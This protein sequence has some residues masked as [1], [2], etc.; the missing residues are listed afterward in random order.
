MPVL[1]VIG[2]SPECSRPHTGNMEKLLPPVFARLV[3]EP[4]PSNRT[5][6]ESDTSLREGYKAGKI[7]YIRAGVSIVGN[8]AMTAS[9]VTFGDQVTHRA[10]FVTGR[11]ITQAKRGYLEEIAVLQVMRVLSN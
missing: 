6:E 1:N 10:I 11:V 5:Q 2:W 9:V 3:F 8:I 7:I 4:W